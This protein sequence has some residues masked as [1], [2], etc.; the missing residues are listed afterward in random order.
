MSITRQGPGPAGL[1]HASEADALLGEAAHY[2]GDKSSSAAQRL[3][4]L[5]E[6]IDD[7]LLERE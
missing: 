1:V 6:L 4:P 7:R 5:R 2:G 3:G